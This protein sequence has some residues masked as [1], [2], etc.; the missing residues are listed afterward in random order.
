MKNW[1]IACILL[2]AACVVLSGCSHSHKWEDASCTSPKICED[3]GQTE[4][5]A[6]GHLWE[7]PDCIH[8]KKC[9][10]CG[11]EEGAALGH[12]W[13]EATCLKSK[14][15]S[16]C[17]STE[18]EPLGHDWTDANCST[19]KTCSRCLLTEGNALGHDAPE[20]SCENAASCLRCNTEL[21]ALG[22]EWTDATCTEAKTCSRCSAVEGDALGHSA[23][24]P[25]EEKKKAATCTEGGQHDAVVYC[26]RC[27]IE[28]ERETLEE[29]ALG[30]STASGTCSRCG[31]EIYEP[32]TGRG[33]DVIS[34]IDVGDGLYKVHITYSGSRNFVVWV[35]DKD[36][37]R[38]L[39]VNEIGSYD[40]YYFL[41]GAA[42]YTFEIES[43]GNWTI[44]IEK[45][46]TTKKTSFEGQGCYVTDMFSASTGTWHITHNGSSNFIIWL[47]TT[48]GRDLIVN[49]IGEYDGKKRLSIPSGSNAILVIE[50]DGQWSITPAD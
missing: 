32:I 48:D 17:G 37:D 24:E 14:A 11:L 7:E 39:A 25:V 49:E 19:P 6:L 45:I 27:H 10:Q 36:D 18:G 50:A 16:R 34:G 4:G 29:P 22:H 26:E 8:A 42:P 31:T 41:T 12:S 46:G 33:D 9:S 40:G 5:E 38:D 44:T 30:H 2:V 15:C 47:Y 43:S 23:A 35:Y 13:E 20:L 28:L 21:A 1:I 3:C